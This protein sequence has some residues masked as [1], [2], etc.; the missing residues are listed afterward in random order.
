MTDV[1]QSPV[2]SVSGP[3]E[4]DKVCR[5][6]VQ[7]CLQARLR[8]DTPDPA[9]EIGRGVLIYTCFLQ[10]ATIE[11]LDSIVKAVLNAKLSEDMESLETPRQSL[12]HH[13]LDVLI[14]PQATLGGRLKGKGVQY[15]GLVSKQLGEDLYKYFAEK[16]KDAVESVGDG[17]GRVGKGIYGAR[18]ILSVETNGPFTH[19]FEF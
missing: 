1:T 12:L 8:F 2:T 15:H 3:G 10:R 19:V 5:I 9:V 18:Q 13:K 4:K 7:Q 6:V 16:V 14:I 17:H 11:S